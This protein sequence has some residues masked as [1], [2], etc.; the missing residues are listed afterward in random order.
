ML[1]EGLLDKLPQLL[2]HL[3]L[4][5]QELP[6]HVVSSLKDTDSVIFNFLAFGFSSS[7]TTSSTEPDFSAFGSVA[8]LSPITS[9]SSIVLCRSSPP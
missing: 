6:N 5:L 7:S 4:R 2:K 1:V 9:A 3:P 8:D